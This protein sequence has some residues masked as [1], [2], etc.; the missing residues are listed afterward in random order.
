MPQWHTNPELMFMPSGL[1][2]RPACRAAPLARIFH[3]PIESSTEHRV[4]TPGLQAPNYSSCRPGALTRRRECEICGLGLFAEPGWA[5]AGPA[6]NAGI[7]GEPRGLGLLGRQTKGEVV[8]VSRLRA[9]LE[10][11]CEPQRPRRRIG[12]ETTRQPPAVRAAAAHRATVRRHWP[13]P[14]A[15]SSWAVR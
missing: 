13:I 3:T 1:H 4:R 12:M 15:L 14:A 6:P 11:F 7:S 2:R 10:R 8:L 9:A 5:L